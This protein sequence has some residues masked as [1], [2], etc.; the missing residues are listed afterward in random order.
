MAVKLNLADLSF[1]LRQI[2]ISEAHA[3]GTALTSVWVDANGNVV[4]AGTPGA[5]PAISDPH[6]PYG[7]RTVDGTLNNVVEGRETWG[8]ADQPMPRLLDP[9][10]RVETDGDVM[11]LGPPGGPLVTNGNYGVVGVPTSPM[12]NGGHS[13]NVADA[14]PRII[15]NLVVDQSVSNPAAVAAW[16]ANAIAVANWEEANPGLV[17][18]R[19]GD[20]RVGDGTHVAIT[21]EDLASLPNIAPDEGL[22]APFNAWM[23]FFGQ[24]FD[25]GLDLIGK[26]GN[27]TVYIPLQPDDPL[28]LGADGIAGTD[29]DLLPQL[30]FMALTR[31]TPTAGPGPDGIMG[32]A[33][34]TN[35]E[36]NNSTTPFVDQNQTYTSHASHQVFL[37]EYEL[38]SNGRPV[39]TGHLLD[40]ANGGLATWGD[41][42]A[43]ARDLLGIELSDGDVLNIPLLR[44]DPYGAFI[45][46]PNGLPQIV[47]GVGP[48]GIPN[49]A[50]DIVVE[51]N[52][53]APVNTFSVGAIRIGH[54]FLDDIAHAANPFDGRTGTLKTADDDDAVGLSD[55][56]STEGRYDNELLDRHFITGDGRGNENIGLTAVHHVFHSEH[57]RQV[58]A[59]KLTVLL[60]GDPAFVNEWLDAPVDAGGLAAF[61]AGY[62]SVTD[63]AAYLAGSSFFQSLDWN[64]ERLFQSARFATEMQYQHLVFEEFARKI[65][66]NVEPFVFNAV[67]D[68]NPAI[69][70]EFANVV[71]RFGH[72]MLTDSMPRVLADGSMDDMGLIDAFLNPVAYDNDGAISADEAAAAVIRGMTTEHGNAIDEF[73]VGSLR[74]NLVGLPLDLAALNIARGRDTGM[75]TFN[76]TRAQLFTQTGSPW[77][78]PYESWFDLAMNL[79][80]TMTVVNLIAAYGLHPT[81][82]AAETLEEKRQAALDLVL[83]GGAVSTAERMDFLHGRGAWNAQNSGLNDI[84]LWVG[85][86]AERIMP[87]GG[88]LGSTFTAIFEAQ[89]EMLQF[90]DRFYYLSRVQGQNFLNELEQNSFAKI[91]LA[92]TALSEPGPDG[93]RGT[94][95]DIVRRHIGADS[96]ARY[97]HVLEVDR[98]YQ[99]EDDPEADD[100]ILAGF[101]F[102]KVM[103]DNPATPGPDTNYLRFT[104][105][106]HVVIG[107]TSGNDTI[108]SSDGDDA[109]W[110]D[111]GDD[112]ISA[113]FGVDLVNA[114]GGNDIVLDEGDE[115]DF[116]KGEDGDDVMATSGGLDI[117]MGGNGKD[118]IFL[119]ADSSEVFGGQGDD[120]IMGGQGH[121]FLMGNEGD[122]WIE[123]GP[124]FDV[125]SGDN[126][127]LFF[128]SRI[129]GHDVM[130]AGSDEQDFDAESGDDIM[131]QGESVIRNEGMFGFDWATYQ[132]VAVAANADMRIRIFTTDEQDILRN[133]FDKVEALSG[134][135]LNDTLT[136]DDRVA[137]DALGE[138]PDGTEGFFFNDGLDQAGIDRITGLQDL[139]SIGAGRTHWEEGNILLGGGGSDLITGNG[140]NDIIDGDRW[141]N[142]RI[143]IT[144]A[145][146]QENTAA[147]QIATVTTLKHVFTATDGVDASWVG[148][149]LFE[150]LVARTIV[151]GQMHIVRE[152][153][154]GNRPG[155][156]DI[157]VFNDDFA[158]YTITYLPGN[159][160]QVAHTGFGNNPDVLTD[161]GTD[162]LHNIEMMRFRDRDVPVNLAPTGQPAISDTT[163]TEGQPLTV[164]LS[165]IADGNGIPGPIAVQWQSSA[166]GVTWTDIPGATGSSFTPQDLAGPT[167]GA[168]AGLM[169]RARASFTDGIGASEVVFSAPT[170]PVGQNWQANTVTLAFSGTAGDDVANGN[171]FAN[172]LQGNDGSDVL[173]GLGGLD[174]LDGGAGDD[175]L[176]G[177]GGADQLNGGLGNDTLLGGAAADL[178]DGGDGNDL[179]NGGAGADTLAG[180]A[181][182]DLIQVADFGLAA[183]ARDRINGGDGM[184]TVD[185]TGTA[186]A[187]T[188]GIFTRAFAIGAGITGA[189][190]TS[191]DTEIIITRNGIMIA[192]LDN[193]EEIVINALDATPPAAGTIGGDSIIVGG[194]FTTTSLNLST[195]TVNGSTGD[196]SV[197]ISSL[198]SAHRI[199]FRGAGGNDVMVGSVRPQ[200]VIDL[201]GEGAI[202]IA[203]LANGMTRVSRGDAS[204]TFMAPAGM[205]QIPG[206]VAADDDAANGS[207]ALS[208]RDL[209]A[210]QNIVQGRP[211][212][213]NDDDS[214]GAAGVRSLSGAGNNIANP[215][216]GAAGETFIR[217]TDA[218]YGD[219]DPATGNRAVNPIFDGLDPRT[220]SNILGAQ[221]P[222][223]APSAL[224]ANILFMAFGQ[225]FDHGLDFI[226][227]SPAFGTI[228]IG[229]PGMER[230]PFSDN[231]ADLTRAVVDHIDANGIPQHV[232]MTSPF[233]DQ[234]QAYGSHELVGQFL[235]ESDGARGFGMRL[236]Q[237]E[238]DPSD[239]GFTLLPT[240]RD[241]IL[242]HW[243]ADTV[244]RD[245][246]LPGGAVAFRTAYAGL[247]DA[248]GAI[249]AAMVREL[250]GNFLGSGQ[251][252]LLDA[253]PFISLLDHR[254]A[255]DGRANENFALTAV[256]TIWARNHNFHVDNLIAQGFAGTA[257]EVF[258]AAK[259][260]NESDYQRVVFQEFAD[261][262]LGG[263]RASDGTFSNHGWDGYNPDV[264]ARISHEFAAAV[265]RVGHSLIGQTIQV[266]GPDG[267][268]MQVPL[269]DAFL[270]PT[271]DPAAFTGALPPG[272][273]P[274]PGYA[275]HGVASILAGTAT[276]V[277]EEVDFNIVDA[278]RN[279]LV[280]INADLF[281][282]NVARGWDV[283]LGTLNQ[284][285]ASLAASA[286][287]YIAQAVGFAGDLSPY[288]SWEDFQAR[289]G[290]SDAVIA[291]FRA[292][293]PD[294]VLSTPEAV[295]AFVAVNPDIELVDG[296]NG[297]KIVKGID[298]VDLW[299]GGLA[300]AH[301]N[302]GMVGQTFW[303]VLHEQ[304]DRL[305]EGD[306]FYYIDRFENFDFYQSFG[307]DTTFANIIARNTS[308]TGLDSTIFDAINDEADEDDG[309]D[310]DDDHDD[311]GAGA[312][313][314][315]GNPG[316]GE[317]GGG[318][319]DDETGSGDDADADTGSDDDAPGDD[320]SGDGDPPDGDGDQDEDDGSAVGSD[321]EDE[322]DDDPAG[323]SDDEEDEDDGPV[324]VPPIAASG[325]MVGTAAADALFGTA[326]AENM[327]GMAGRDMMFGGAGNDNM[328][329]GAGA[330]MMF[331]EEGDDRLFG[332]EGDDLLEGG[333]GND[334]VVGGKGNDL[335]RATEGDGN[336]VYYGDDVSGGCGT[337]TL[338][339]SA[340]L[341][342]ITVDLG[343]GHGGRGMA[344]SAA[345]GTD[346][347]W[348]IE[349]FVGGAGDDVITAGRAANVMDGGAGRD[350]YRFLSAQDADGDTIA[351]FEPGDRIDLSAIDAN[352]A[353]AG[354]G[355]FVLVSGAFTGVGQLAVRHGSDCEGDFTLVEGNTSGDEGAEFSIRLRGH[356]N[357]T[358]DD[359]QL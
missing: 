284:I 162:T 94:A 214:E 116:L 31:A 68:I 20:P 261:K 271:N 260:L 175:L 43:Q 79:K 203:N 331:G 141:L 344:Q 218:R 198:S 240:L 11:P 250:A 342:N 273:V 157:A 235:R 120:F 292:A 7:L 163:P 25:H 201:G 350:T 128:N 76:E 105:G 270:N 51:G 77:L 108:I 242:H 283:G 241:L 66:P 37:R 168:Q 278:V 17:P 258:Q 289:N 207:F 173:N 123:G 40:G 208:D 47:T 178:L 254:V 12:V 340:I 294:L 148:K 334:L 212:F 353:A 317:T 267:Q 99:M 177:G 112:F 263:L 215:N 45:R 336:D 316:G 181:G 34:D 287:P 247:V 26:G 61:I 129:I 15:S 73:V 174:T 103:R 114:G 219:L 290:L 49:T 349:N 132:G 307:E 308:L 280:R 58:E 332:E 2:K 253:N 262:L 151:P 1:I 83:G 122:D 251:P 343:T 309:A 266:I 238:A 91:L 81:I 155:D 231:P 264:D 276:Q 320:A 41:I 23:T 98:A 352:G 245:P 200:D 133:R 33:D 82:T 55:S 243:Q 224:N 295:A 69:F 318:N 9:N 149:S 325:A 147:N 106:E 229:G 310:Q 57:N 341:A 232:N 211:A 252:L 256:H 124:G 139:V 209:A 172:L 22:T 237:G 166:D 13:G 230:G 328:L 115:A 67:T 347:L 189:A 275:Q 195:I 226:P 134:W 354:K 95:D 216:Y 255:G 153:L 3:S 299:V 63:K 144:G 28:V 89:L 184:D 104:G 102:T 101:G 297:E 217:L 327:L 234:N 52:L 138:V 223:L 97:D 156:Q 205:P 233:V 87:F 204:V 358:A 74:N 269:F 46:G 319:A 182:D 272:Y 140:G 145:P 36:G 121:D 236:L 107:G 75:P 183:G 92:N 78:R 300:E 100:P 304:F 210:L 93:I 176:D 306:R 314:T 293:Y 88:M 42:K 130:F 296:P 196:D 150:L 356:H 194:D 32:T 312:G 222:G 24:F 111:A 136:G 257:E 333:A 259:M 305:Q 330:D 117:L 282:F 180:G 179:L 277:A 227:K 246:G 72:S 142:V 339:M 84:D 244:F 286:N 285:R 279:D 56:T 90:G 302:G 274:Q 96:F 192:E 291:Q 4:P 322:Q 85:G 338:D 298:R 357:L 19:P 80:T 125:I 30:R 193:I 199:V 337:D 113:G 185:I 71:Y 110:G 265:Y 38:D 228:A 53:S 54:A 59:H 202:E 14:D 154:D 206:L 160:V 143:R 220:I 48:D 167:P 348:S 109:I 359:F 311:D 27:G 268:P 221:E 281:A 161:D 225:Y 351:S 65:H 324:T 326:A 213:D 187:E 8:A 16:F 321:D 171:G 197:D 186:D 44:T 165:G 64:G 60:G 126:T 137:L 249:D 29:D 345:T 35:H 118:V 315:G 152:I 288:T 119:G 301:I 21:N 335:F 158:N 5:V 169:L 346:V 135:N 323:G 188:F 50:D 191:L 248:S 190:G 127:E 86:L 62:N 239:P 170:A 313:D 355:S 70:A 146:G 303:V 18:V 131:V 164:D 6:V 159:I 39:A 329:G 10:W